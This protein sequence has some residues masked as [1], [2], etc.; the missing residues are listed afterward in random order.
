M[1]LKILTAVV[2]VVVM[3]LAPKFVKAQKNGACPKSLALKMSAATGYVAVGAL[4]IAFTGEFSPF[5]K[6]LFI[7][8]LLSWVG[9]LSLHLWMHKAFYGV[10]FLG[11][12]SAHFFFIAAYL[13][14]IE[15]MTP[16]RG[17][18]SVPE[19][20]FVA[21]FDI[22]FIIFAIKTGMNLKG[23]IAVPI[24][25]YSTVITTMLSKA[26]VLGITAVKTGADNA[27]LTLICAVAGA[28][29]FVASDFTISILMFNEKQKTNYPLKMFNIVTYFAAE[30][31]LAL[32][33][34]LI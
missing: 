2:C 20:A 25:I 22:F 32:L 26:A 33:I 18:F 29:L 31:L 19:V 12:L 27:V 10:G 5:D 21:A 8:L 17:F 15:A 14:G 34:A 9:D 28:L 13:R 11:F 7:A 6:A 16:G 24:V 23:I 4:C 30:L 1:I 3:V